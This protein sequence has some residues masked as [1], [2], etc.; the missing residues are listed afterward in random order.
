MKT[1]ECDCHNK[2]QAKPK[3]KTAYYRKKDYHSENGYT[4]FIAVIPNSRAR[5][6]SP[7]SR[8]QAKFNPDAGCTILHF[9]LSPFSKAVELKISGRSTIARYRSYE[10]CTKEQ[11]IEGYE[12]IAD[13][14]DTQIQ[15]LIGIT[16]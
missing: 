13:E 2:P 7:H 14:F 10:P 5:I 1:C 8:V 4:D 3:A 6:D 15:K 11:F 12:T 16:F 9:Q